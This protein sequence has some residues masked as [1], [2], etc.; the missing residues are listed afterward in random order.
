MPATALAE[1]HTYTVLQCHSLNRS[2]ADAVLQD[3]PSYAVHGD[4]GDPQNDYAIRITNSGPAK[5]GG[6]GWM[7]WPTGSNVLDIVRVDA[8]AKL[9][10]ESGHAA[11]LW[12]A[13]PQANEVVRIANGEP[14]PT[15]YRHYSWIAAGHG[16][17]QFVATL[18]CQRSEGCPESDLAKTY[19]RN[20]RLKVAD[21]S[22]PSFKALR[23]LAAFGWLASRS[24]GPLRSG[25]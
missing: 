23:R 13:D 5:H 10:R 14:G 11:R 21:Y 24:G 16:Q 15:G 4:C 6:A 2:H 18:S 17:R 1:G 8:D 3:S 12:M 19:V 22:D 7:R 20:V 9:R 25:R